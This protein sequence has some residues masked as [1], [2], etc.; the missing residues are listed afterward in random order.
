MNDAEFNSLKSRIEALVKFWIYVLGLDSWR[1][2]R[3]DYHRG[4]A[5]G[6]RDCCADVDIDW[7]YRQGVVTFHM[8]KMWDHVEDDKEIEYVVVHELCHFLVNQ[9]RP[10]D[11][12]KG[13]TPNEEDVVTAMARGYVWTH[14]AGVGD[15][16]VS[17]NPHPFRKYKPAPAVTMADF[18]L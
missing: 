1:M 10:A 17:G 11:A 2:V 14:R 6:S 12:D 7:K 3:R 9:M 15:L 4:R 8:Y 18:G 5:D 13:S 16:D